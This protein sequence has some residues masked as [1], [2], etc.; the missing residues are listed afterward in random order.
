MSKGRKRKKKKGGSYSWCCDGREVSRPLTNKQAMSNEDGSPYGFHCQQPS[1]VSFSI[2]FL[3]PLKTKTPRIA[4]L[5]IWK[6]HV[7]L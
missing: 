2:V 4:F 5:C 3:F 7:S 6:F 1:I